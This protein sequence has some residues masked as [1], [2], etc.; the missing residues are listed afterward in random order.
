MFLLSVGLSRPAFYHYYTTGL[1]VESNSKR[2]FIFFLLNVVV[3]VKVFENICFSRCHCGKQILSIMYLR[4]IN[5][6]YQ[7]A[8]HRLYEEGHEVVGVELSEL[9]VQS[10][11]D[12]YYKGEYDQRTLDGV[13][14]KLFSTRDGRL[15]IYQMDFYTFGPYALINVII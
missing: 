7:D 8:F 5:C 1:V 13:N 11:F 14:G 15:R 12:K 3:I 4:S 6:T 10:F 2:G 9:T